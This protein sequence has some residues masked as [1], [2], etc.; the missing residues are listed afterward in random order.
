[1]VRGFSPLTTTGVPCREG[2]WSYHGP[3]KGLRTFTRRAGRIGSLLSETSWR[4]VGSS[5][6]FV[7]GPPL[8][9]IRSQAGD[10][11]AQDGRREVGPRGGSRP[12]FRPSWGYRGGGLAVPEMAGAR[13]HPCHS[14]RKGRTAY[15]SSR[16]GLLGLGEPLMPFSLRNWPKGACHRQNRRRHAQLEVNTYCF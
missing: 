4:C 14:S 7:R 8:V 15:Q 1:M 5:Q 12:S 6:R 10:G 2:V 13:R 3:V 16:L 9:T 11:G